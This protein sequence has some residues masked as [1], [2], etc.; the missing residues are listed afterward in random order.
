M[1]DYLE[2]LIE[3]KRDKP[4]DDVMTVIA[5]TP[6]IDGKILD[7]TIAAAQAALLLVAGHETTTN[8]IGNTVAL[9]IGHPAAKLRLCE[10]P[11]LVPNA[12]EESLRCD[13][14]FHFDQ[15][16]AVHDTIISGQ[17]V[18][19]GQLTLQLIAAANRDPRQFEHPERFDVERPT[20]SNRHLAFSHGIHFCLGAPLARM[21][22]QIVIEKLLQ[23]FPNI[24]RGEEPPTRKTD[25]VVAR[26][27]HQ[28]PVTC[29]R[30]SDGPGQVARQG[31]HG[32]TT[33]ARAVTAV[34]TDRR[35]GRT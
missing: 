8:L 25:A 16:K 10:R 9:L 17:N 32:S 22:A 27:W 15:R 6:T 35:G 29:S 1:F 5:T 2:D 28:L 26:G 12:I 18:S 34:I 14:P 13:P 11:D 21:E 4:G 23:Q 31:C 19:S 24:S 30:R 3:R 33:P 7:P 20:A